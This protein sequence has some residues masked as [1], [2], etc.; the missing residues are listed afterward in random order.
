MFTGIV[1]GV[2]A[3]TVVD[4]QSGILHY[5]VALPLDLS[6]HLELGASVSIDG[7][8]QTVVQ[9]DDNHV[10]FDAIDETLQRTTLNNIHVGDHVNVERSARFGD[11]IGGHLLSGHIYGRVR[12]DS[13]DGNV[14]TFACDPAWMKYLFSK[15]FIALNGCSLTLVDVDRQR[16]VFTVHLI[17]ET[18]RRTT[19]AHKRVGDFVNLEL[20]AMTQA[21]VETVE[22]M[23]ASS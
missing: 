1:K 18:L 14:W 23:S 13:V 2:G 10:S 15:G 20:D 3:I 11:E 5:T 7:V 12:I 19:F 9:L 16:G 4:R 6:H 17:P 8:C 21:V 22:R